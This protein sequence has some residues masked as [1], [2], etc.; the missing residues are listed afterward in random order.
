MTPDQRKQGA[1]TSKSPLKEASNYHLVQLYVQ[2]VDLE[3]I[4]LNTP[5]VQKS[6]SES[7]ETSPVETNFLNLNTANQI[8]C[9]SYEHH[10]SGSEHPEVFN[11]F[12]INHVIAT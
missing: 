5:L 12:V 11:S 4:R 9:Y 1:F 8:V 7:F 3:K 10:S 2:L 6:S